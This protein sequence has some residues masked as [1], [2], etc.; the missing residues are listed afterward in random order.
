MI[1][2]KQPKKVWVDKG[3]SFKGSYEALCKTKG[4]KTYCTEGAKTSLFAARIIQSL[5][6]LIYKC[7]EDNWT[8]IYIKKLKDFV[9]AFSSRANRVT[10]LAQTKVTKKDVFRMV[11][12]K[13]TSHIN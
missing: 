1:A 5:K 11:S 3:T 7:L 2:T 9:N 13:Q 6:N 12:S 8:Y 4:M 10:N